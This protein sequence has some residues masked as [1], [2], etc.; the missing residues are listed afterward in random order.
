MEKS[1][2]PFLVD[3]GLRV[4]RF[5]NL[6]VRG[7]FAATIP[8]EDRVQAGLLVRPGA[9]DLL[10]DD[11]GVH[12]APA[13]VVPTAGMTVTRL[14]REDVPFGLGEDLAPDAVIYRV[15]GRAD[16]ARCRVGC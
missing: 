6:G 11:L 2:V 16:R 12:Q 7:I 3:G 8:S 5:K 15:S 13:I 1:G 4:H 9:V 10:R 14:A